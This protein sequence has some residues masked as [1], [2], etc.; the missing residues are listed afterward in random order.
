LDYLQW[1]TQG[2][3]VPPLVTAA[4]FGSRGV[5]GGPDTVVLLGG[6][7]IDGD[8]RSGARGRLGYWFDCYQSR[9]VQFEIFGLQREGTDF[10]AVSSFPDR[11]IWR[12]FYNTDP[13]VDAPDA[14]FA[15][16]VSVASTSELYSLDF[17]Y[18]HNLV[19]C[20]D[21]CS[22]SGYHVDALAG[23][24]HFRLKEALAIRETASVFATTFDI[25]DHFQTD[26]RFDGVDLG[27]VGKVYR[28]SL[29]LELLAKVALGNNRQRVTVFGQEITT[30]SPLPP[31]MRPGGLLAQ[32]TNSRQETRDRFAVI[33]EIGA[34][35]GYQFA[36]DLRVTLGYSFIF[37]SHVVRPGDQIDPAVDGRFLDPNL[38][39]P[40]TPPA[41]RPAPRFSPSDMWVQGLNVGLEW[42]Y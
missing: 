27:V 31:S 3:A 8:T 21:D 29:S 40:F 16:Q 20:F 37:L 19:C 36:N 24:R 35:L 23:Y 12:P 25:E 9:G 33:P 5:L 39:P 42:R 30:T 28:G 41:Q 15:D 7:R 1:W 10:T 4:P 32:S 11:L 2:Y 38:V 14:Q 18:R 22:W 17:L 6:D 26:N 13:A 34:E